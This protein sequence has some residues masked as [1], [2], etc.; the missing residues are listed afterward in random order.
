MDNQGLQYYQERKH[1]GLHLR[2]MMPLIYILEKKST[3]GLEM[4]NEGVYE[5]GIILPIL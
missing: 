3:H 4:R 2:H 1:I 5:T